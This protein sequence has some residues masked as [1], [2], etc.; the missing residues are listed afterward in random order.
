MVGLMWRNIGMVLL[1][2]GCHRSDRANPA[3]A[4]SGSAP[5]TQRVEASSPREPAVDAASPDAAVLDVLRALPR[6]P[7]NRAA[8][9]AL[10]RRAMTVHAAKDYR[11]SERLWAEAAHSDPSWDWPYYN[12]ACST[13]LQARPDEAIGYLK[14]VR[15]R[16]PDSEMLHRIETDGDLDAVRR[17]PE[18]GA[19]VL[20]IARA[21][22]D[23]SGK[24]ITACPSDMVLIPAGAFRMGNPAGIGWD[25]ERP[26]HLVALSAYCIDRTEVTVEAY[27]ACVGGQGCEAA[28]RAEIDYHHAPNVM[29]TDNPKCNREDRPDHPMNCVDWDHATAYCKWANKRLPT[30]A[31]WEYAAR[32]DDDRMYPWGNQQPSAALV[33]GCEH[34]CATTVV[35]SYPAGASRF[36]VLDMAG[37]VEEWIADWYDAYPAAAAVNP[38]GETTGSVR[39]IRG[40]SWRDSNASDLRATERSGLYPTTRIITLGFR[41]VRAN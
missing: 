7:G 16:E 26:Q 28:P 12:L 4:G 37:N 23:R 33:S 38:S 6:Q 29:K 3:P 10:H 15:D 19:V 27:A 8:A 31:E 9:M 14:L 30:E 35:G 34:E 20:A 32:G 11:E 40:G 5:A 39:V 17:R 1:A 25:R 22:A 13:A 21:I 2:A 41:C 18:Y 36:G 24:P